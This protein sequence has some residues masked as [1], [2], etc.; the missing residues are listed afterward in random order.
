M[1][2]IDL[3]IITVTYNAE[4]FV[5]STIISV[6]NQT[7]EDFEYIL[8]DGQSTDQTPTIL[9]EYNN[10]ID[11]L[12]IEPDQGV[13]DAMNKGLELAKGDYVLFLNAGD[14]FSGSTVLADVFKSKVDSDLDLDPDIIYGETNI[15]NQ[16]RQ[17][18]GT[19]SELTSR[20]LPDQ[21]GKRDFLNGQVVSHQSF[22]AKRFLCKPYDLKYKCSADIDWMMQIISESKRII[23]VNQSIANYLQGGISDTKLGVCWKERFII[24][25]KYFDLSSVIISHL[26]FVI[27]FLRIGR[28]R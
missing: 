5:A 10:E 17:V 21:L 13:Y 22:I 7:F 24:M 4:K 23:N 6:A 25:L 18:I 26:K 27:R 16:D 15:I 12:V 14:E 11:V 19:R 8:I 20:K 1:P 3:S 28:Y 2:K 9:N